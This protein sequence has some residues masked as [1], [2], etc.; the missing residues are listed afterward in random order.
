LG[1]ATIFTLKAARERARA[2]RVQLADGIDPLAT[3]HAARAAARAEAAKALT[4]ATA[5]ARYFEQHSP[6]WTDAKHRQ[7]FLASMRDYVNPIIGALP[8]AAVD[9]PLVL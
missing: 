7:Q 6:K 5:A 9:T 3:K 4:F 2:A 1:S 8:V